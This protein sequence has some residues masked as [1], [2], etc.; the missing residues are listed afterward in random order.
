MGEID[1]NHM[2]Q[3][4]ECAKPFTLGGG[5]HL[6]TVN[7]CTACSEKPDPMADAS[8][9]LARDLLEALRLLVQA[10]DGMKLVESLPEEPQR[11]VRDVLTRFRITDENG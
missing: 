3:C 1:D 7:I 5:L 11:R 2:F 9:R 4:A 8:T 10:P 6:R